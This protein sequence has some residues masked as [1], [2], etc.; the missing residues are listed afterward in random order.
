MIE[1]SDLDARFRAIQKL[2]SIRDRHRPGSYRH[3]VADYAIDLALS[4]RRKGNE[5][6]VRN[7]LRD[8]SNILRR[9]IR[10][11]PAQ[12]SLDAEL[13]EQTQVEVTTLHDLV[14][15]TAPTPAERCEQTDLEGVLRRRLGDASSPHRLAL[16]SIVVGETA[17]EFSARTNL[18]QS[19]FK[20]LKSEIR[21]EAKRLENGFA[22]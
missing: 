8:A 11:R 16:D 1:K 18:S 5:F 17:P 3:D 22:A 13:P 19:Y 12:F 21:D 15:A 2:Q 6:L 20:K 14:P 4:E 9:S 7:T 10:R